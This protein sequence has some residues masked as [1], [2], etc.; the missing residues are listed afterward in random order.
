MLE[1]NNYAL[2]CSKDINPWP[3]G[4]FHK[5]AGAQYL[6]MPPLRHN[7]GVHDPSGLTL[8]TAPRESSGSAIS[9]FS[10]GALRS[11]NARGSDRDGVRG[12]CLLPHGC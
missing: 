1:G 7:T 11:A 10:A 4:E 6:M 5:N 3:A 12:V 9:P 8:I 2:I